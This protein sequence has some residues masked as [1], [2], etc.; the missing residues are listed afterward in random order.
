M[1]DPNV[2]ESV[3]Q[4]HL[5]DE[6][7]ELLVTYYGGVLSEEELDQKM[8]L[9]LHAI[10]VARRSH[11]AQFRR[12]GEPYIFHPLRVA[13]LAARNWMD[14]DSICAAMLHD[15][16][17]DTPVTLAEIEKD[18]GYKIAFLING[19]TKADDE[20]LSRDALRNQTY[21]RQLLTA[22]EDVRALC[23]KFWD[24]IDNLQTIKAL[25]PE[26][27]RL[28][29]EETER[30]YVPLALRLGMGYVASELDALSLAV[31]EPDSYEEYQKTLASLRVTMQP[32]LR[33]IRRRIINTLES[34]KLSVHVNDRWR[35]FSLLAAR[36][37]HRGFPKLYTM[38]I[39]V[40]RTMDAYVALGLLHGMFPP[41]PGK[42]EDHLTVPSP[43]GYQA[44]HTT[45]Q[46]DQYRMRVEITTYKLARFN[47]SGVLAPGFDFH[48]ARFQDLVKTLLEGNASVVDV[49]RLR[50][51]TSNVR[52]YTPTGA[53]RVLPEGSSVLDF[54][55][56][57]HEELGLH[58]QY[59]MV[60]GKHRGLD[61]HLMDGD[62]VEII[63]SAEPEVRPKWLEWAITSK[64]LNS[65][66]RYLRNHPAE[67]PAPAKAA[68]EGAE[69]SAGG[70]S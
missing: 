12:S 63:R 21:R 35:S 24:R 32:W 55:F 50:L 1:A 34:C 59:G 64:A 40:G 60:N 2:N 28:I 16:V 41:I 61:F 22:I 68:P 4:Q 38:E 36:A 62:Q 47:R 9:L 8:N 54:A 65:I 5:I 19:L 70:A 52:V 66:R 10:D 3:Q 33:Q 25:A 7:L 51:A 69:K 13:H 56:E 49:E 27:Q 57:I 48:E 23:L 67:K 42:L 14:F 18:F 37:V 43:H 6:T 29:A 46:A 31:L 45:V 26:K 11:D 58:A 17:E 44:L 53:D 20:H 39:D 15:V 30:I